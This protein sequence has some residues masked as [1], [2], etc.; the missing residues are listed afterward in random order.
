VTHTDG[1]PN[2]RP[3]AKRLETMYLDGLLANAQF[4]D[5]EALNIVPLVTLELDD[6]AK[7][8]IIDK[9]TVASELLLEG[10]ENQFMV[11]FI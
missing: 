3:D 9:G 10:L 1:V 4:R 11:V 8:L 5:E 7:L 2:P 6:F